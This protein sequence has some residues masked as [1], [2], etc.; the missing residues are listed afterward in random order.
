MQKFKRDTIWVFVDNEGPC[1]LN[2]NAQETMVELTQR[3][4][5]GE[6]VGIKAYKNLSNIDDIWGDFHKLAKDP[7][8]SSGHTLKVV[9]PF[10]KAMGAKIEWLY[11]FARES[12][13]LV[14]NIRDVINNLNRKYNLRMIST[15]YE[16]FIKAFCDSVNLD[17]AKVRCT[18]VERF[19]EISITDKERVLLLSFLKEIAQMP[20][21]QYDS[22]TGEVI[23]EH[24]PYYERLTGFIWETLYNMPV[25]EFLKMVKPVG[26]IQKREVLQ[27]I[28]EKFNVSKNKVMYVGDSQTDVECVRFLKG[29]GLTVMFNGKGQVCHLSDIMYIGEDARVIEE[30]ADLFAQKGRHEVIGYYSNP[31]TTK[32]GGLVATVTKENIKELE[33]MSIR[34]RKEFRG[35]HIG[36]LT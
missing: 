29:T 9:L 24:Q 3:C 7:T 32:D 11:N 35:V 36:D 13:R 4:G 5:L 17:F 26:Q 12:L 6:E 31:R 33:Q 25:G 23:K 19:D 21:I 16:F 18:S 8:Y 20:T 14:P 2:D 1:T 22:K 34:K 10:Y 28:C 27:E 30:I 15:S